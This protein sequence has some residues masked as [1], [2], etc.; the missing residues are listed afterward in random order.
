MTIKNNQPGTTTN[1]MLSR[2]V[3]KEKSGR[4][5]SA[6]NT[7][8]IKAAA[9]ALLPVWSL[10]SAKLRYPTSSPKPIRKTAANQ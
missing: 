7:L 10:G 4:C 3:A 9:K 8:R 2:P 1:P 5:H 6:Q